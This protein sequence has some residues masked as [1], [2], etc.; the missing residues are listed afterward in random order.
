M[1]SLLSYCSFIR[2]IEIISDKK[3][4]LLFQQKLFSENFKRRKFAIN[5]LSKYSLSIE[6]LFI[7]DSM[8]G[9]V[10]SLSNCLY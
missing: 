7:L 6:N 3:S 2:H 9:N 10:A 1:N 5:H 4:I 8:R